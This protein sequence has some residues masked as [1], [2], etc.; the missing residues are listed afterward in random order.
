MSFVCVTHVARTATL[1]GGYCYRRSLTEE[2]TRPLEWFWA[3][4]GIALYSS[5]D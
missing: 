4:A 3:A 2:C 5:V 1:W